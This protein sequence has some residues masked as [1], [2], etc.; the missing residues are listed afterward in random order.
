MKILHIIGSV[1]PRYG[2]P[3][4]IVL[5]LC[6]EL[7]RQGQE[8]TIFTTNIDGKQNLDVLLDRP[9]Q[10]DGFKIRYFPVQ[11]PRYYMVSFPLAKAL[12]DEIPNF[13]IVHISSVYNFH[14]VVAS[15]YCRKFNVPYLINPH[16]SLDPYLIKRHPIRKR[17]YNSLFLQ[18]DLNH[19]AM[20]HFK[21][22]EEM[23][24]TKPCRIKAPGF[25]IPNGVDPSEFD[26][27][28]PYGF[29]R[30]KYPELNEKKILL[31]FSRINFK[32]GLDI[33]ARAFGEVAQKKDDVYLVLVGPDNEGYATKVKA[34]LQEEE[35]L[36]HSIFTGM[37]LGEDKLAV[38]RDSDI[39]VL[40][41]YTEN[42][43]NAV[44]EAMACDL[45]VIISN[46]VNIWRDVLEASAGIVTDCD[47]HQVAEAILKL[48]DEPKLGKEMGKR[49]KNLVEEKYTWPKAT[50]QMIGIYEEILKNHG[51]NK[52]G[53]GVA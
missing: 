11:W 6:Q 22:Q 15:H 35:T 33:L 28:P 42:F 49:G 30:Q 43:G 40:P 8:V 23:L 47:S 1:A 41:S 34:W 29:F 46:K 25:V 50:K 12:R 27:L 24:L 45:P 20:I 5:E 18:R 2:G 14:T 31:F 26:H 17:I 4:K 37:L 3:S 9:V 16:G 53:T 51:T 39:F 52:L 44:V 19:A 38:L 36:G 10:M 7:G 13:D 32:K 48:L 21:T